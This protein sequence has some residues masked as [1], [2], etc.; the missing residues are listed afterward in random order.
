M[1]T[2]R[3]WSQCQAIAK[4]KNSLG[5]GPTSTSHPDCT[6]AQCA[7]R[8]RNEWST[9][10]EY[11]RR[12]DPQCLTVCGFF[13]YATQVIW[14]RG[15]IMSSNSTFEFMGITKVA[16]GTEKKDSEIPIQIPYAKL[17][18]KGTSI[19]LVSLCTPLTLLCFTEQKNHTNK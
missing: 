1:T 8:M 12:Q 16:E 13:F 9:Y 4:K 5:Y 17:L 11:P 3:P 7:S 15:F 18:G 6:I 14:F 19:H 10:F 2:T